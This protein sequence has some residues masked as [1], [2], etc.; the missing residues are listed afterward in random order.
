MPGEL[1]DEGSGLIRRFNDNTT[2]EGA[3]GESP[4]E[5]HSRLPELN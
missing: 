3:P 4:G 1:A 2:A 5:H